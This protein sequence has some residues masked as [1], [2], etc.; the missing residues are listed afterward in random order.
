M[1][2]GRRNIM[3]MKKQLCDFNV[4]VFAVNQESVA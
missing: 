3:N 1:L 4:I 2:I